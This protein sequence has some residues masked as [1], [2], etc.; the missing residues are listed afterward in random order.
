MNRPS[1]WLFE[2]PSFSAASESDLEYDR[3][4]ALEMVWELPENNAE[5]ELTKGSLPGFSASEEKALRITSTFETGRP[6]GFGG[7]T[8]NFDSMGL[9]FGLLQWNFGSGSLQPLLWE[10]A[11]R[12][13]QRFDAVFGAHAS[14]LR[15]ILQQFRRLNK[16]KDKSERTRIMA[17]QM[18]F[19]ISINHP[20]CQP[21]QK[22]SRKFCQLVEPWATY[23]RK[24][25]ADS[26]FQQIQ[27]RQ[28]RNRMNVAIK[29]AGQFGL[30]SERGLALMFD[31]VTQAG[32][33]WLTCSKTVC[34]KR[35]AIIEQGRATLQQRL[36]RSPTEREMLTL[37]ANVVADTSLPEWREKVRVRK[38][39]IVNGH[40]KVHGRQFD[41]AR[42]FGLSDQPWRVTPGTLPLIVTS[43][44]QR[45]KEIAEKEWEFFARGQKKEHQNGFWQRVGTYWREGVGRRLD[46]RNTKEPW[47]AAF[48]SWVMKKAGAGKQFKYSSGHSVYI[49]DAIAKRKNNDS[50]AAFKGYRLN[51]VAP[52][53]GDLVCGSR[54][55]FVGK[56]SYDT[57]TAYKAHCDIV[58]ATRP[59]EIDLIGGNVNDS[60]SKK[61][62]KVDAQGKIINPSKSLFVVIKNLL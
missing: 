20:N 24:L 11:Q 59:G 57:T 13:S 41:L 15:Q 39:T 17:E 4:A 50:N 18:R 25:E 46:G 10:F 42:D 61:T 7:L 33:A 51:E 26:A 6:L 62:L 2:A 36:G 54:G 44:K 53:V 60:V 52:Q 28:V 43:F 12:H 19:A 30:R 32:S 40:G 55:E 56:V 3:Y 8:G 35:A 16:T 22:S 27:L 47:S 58:V 37:I 1:Q 38:M 48:I 49:R 5:W 31:I 21:K 29:Y 34:K 14:Q 45:V 23:F 9:S